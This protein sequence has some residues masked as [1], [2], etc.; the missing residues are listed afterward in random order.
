M[1]LAQ[2]YRITALLGAA[3][4]AL[5]GRAGCAMD[6]E[7]AIRAEVSAWV[8]PGETLYFDSSMDCT[9]AQFE[10]PNLVGDKS[11]LAYATRCAKGLEALQQGRAVAF[12]V[13]GQSPNAV[14]EQVM[15]QDLPQGLGVLSSG[16]SGKNCMTGGVKA[17]YLSALLDPDAVLFFHPE[18]DGM[19][20]L[21]RSNR[22]LY[23]VRGNV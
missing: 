2:T 7:E 10:V 12:D 19:A 5:T 1:P 6:S 16:I 23:F 13:P 14:S 17:A 3:A 4:L 8:N 22:R 20:V 21:D 18:T 15:T 11:A 9:A